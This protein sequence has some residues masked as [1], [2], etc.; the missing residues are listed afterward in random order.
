MTASRPT[1]AAVLASLSESLPSVAEIA[2]WSSVRN[3]TGRAP[4]WRTSARSFASPM[5]CRPEICAPFEPDREV[6]EVRARVA[7]ATA[8]GVEEELAALG[9]VAG[10]RLELLRALVGELHQD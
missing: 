8:D 7:L 2:V 10:D 6:L 1:S 9:D 3:S 5:L 4:V